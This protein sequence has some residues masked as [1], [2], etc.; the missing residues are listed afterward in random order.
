MLLQGVGTDQTDPALQRLFREALECQR[1]AVSPAVK[2]FGANR[3]PEEVDQ[4]DGWT[5]KTF[6][7]LL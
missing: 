1:V 2:V 5:Q 4:W 7:D 6:N 3:S